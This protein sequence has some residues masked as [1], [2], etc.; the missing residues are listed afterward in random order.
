MNLRSYFQKIR[1]IEQSLREA[2]VVVVSQETSDGGI[3]GLLTEV[4]K[5]LAAR[6]IADGRAGL[7]SEEAGRDFHEKKLEAKR[8]ADQEAVAS[9]MQVTLVPTAEL[10]KASRISKE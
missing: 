3:Q 4:P 9:R 2:F 7:A 6:M 5:H 1:E 10:K 8:L